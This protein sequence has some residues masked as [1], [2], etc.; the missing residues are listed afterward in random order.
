[1]CFLLLVAMVVKVIL[2]FK[3]LLWKEVV[4]HAAISMD[5]NLLSL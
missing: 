3:I 5:N 4:V 2:I 1:M